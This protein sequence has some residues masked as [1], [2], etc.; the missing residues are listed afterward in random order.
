VAGVCAKPASL[1]SSDLA[2]RRP[3]VTSPVFSGIGPQDTPIEQVRQAQGGGA[4]DN[5]HSTFEVEGRSFL[6]VIRMW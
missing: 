2:E 3:D 4:G 6:S 1:M 5:E